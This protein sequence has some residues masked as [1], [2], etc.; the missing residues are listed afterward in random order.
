MVR[1]NPAFCSTKIAQIQIASMRS[2]INMDTGFLTRILQ[3]FHF[4]GGI[5]PTCTRPATDG[6]HSL[7]SRSTLNENNGTVSRTTSIHSAAAHRTQ[8]HVSTSGTDFRHSAIAAGNCIKPVT[9]F[10]RDRIDT[11][12]KPL[13]VSLLYCTKYLWHQRCRVSCNYWQKHAP[14]AEWSRL[15]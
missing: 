11:K 7:S 2:L 1:K 5:Y 9:I 10:I 4:R 3:Q 15:G 12:P 8:L 14:A 13:L 6:V